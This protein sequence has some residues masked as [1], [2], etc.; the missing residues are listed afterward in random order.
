[1]GLAYNIVANNLFYEDSEPTGIGQLGIS[2]I[3]LI[4][5]AIAFLLLMYLLYR[6]TYKPLLA[7][8]D[9]RR[10]LASEIV[11]ANQ[12]AKQDLS[13]AEERQKATLDEARRQAQDIINQAKAIQDRTVNEASEKARQSAEQ[14]IEQ[15]RQQINLER[16]QAIAQL[17]REFAD[18]AVLAATRVVKQELQS[19]S[20]L[21]NKLIN[22]TLSEANIRR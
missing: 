3:N 10:A 9:K 8:I 2:P 17:R 19:N 13:Q 22:E 12:K 6:F 11:E 14:I 18:L 1:M 4:I 7:V 20:D 21:R 5:Q 16:D 15:A